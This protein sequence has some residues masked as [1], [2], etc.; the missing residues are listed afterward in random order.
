MGTLNGKSREIVEVMS[1][2]K[3]DVM[4][5]QEVRWR[6]ERARELGDGYKIYYVGEQS[7]RNGVGVIVSCSLVDSVVDVKRCSSRLM[8]LKLVWNGIVVNVVS[9]YAP[10]AGLGD[11]EK[12]QFWVMYD[13]LVSGV[14]EGER[15][16]VR[17]DLNGHVVKESVGFSMVH[18][19]WGYG[20][21]NK[22]GDAILEEALAHGLVILNTLFKKEESHL[23]TYE[24]GGRKTQVDYIMTRR[25]DKRSCINCKV[26]REEG[27]EEQHK[28][29]VADMTWRVKQRGGV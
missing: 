26:L 28:V 11:E 25:Q 6:G 20:S 14:S 18:G 29:V 12:E 16:V 19:G 5:V 24:S 23:V 4:C 22:E 3:I 8:K 9:V 15:L 10:Q 1:R 17:G 13:A 21:R 2:R 7:G 27:E